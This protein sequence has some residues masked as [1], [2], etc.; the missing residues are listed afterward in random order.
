M[1]GCMKRVVVEVPLLAIGGQFFLCC[2]AMNT[3]EFM[4]SIYREVAEIVLRYLEHQGIG[5]GYKK[6]YIQI[7]TLPLY[8]SQQAI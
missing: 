1:D 8:I 5:V 2:I 3:G 6:M 7:Q 4:M